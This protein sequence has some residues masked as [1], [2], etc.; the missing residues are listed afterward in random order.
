MWYLY[1]VIERL[2]SDPP[3]FLSYQVIPYK[4]LG[5][6]VEEKPWHLDESNK[7]DLM[8]K[9]LEHQKH[10]ER[11]MKKQL[12]IPIQFATVV[13][14]VEAV[15][16][17]LFQNYRLFRDALEDMAGKWEA[18]V[19]VS[20]EVKSQLKKI[21]ACDLEVQAL[22]EHA[23][24]SKAQED[25]VQVG[26]LLEAKLGERREELSSGIIAVLDTLD[27]TI[28]EHEPLENRIVL[29]RSYLLNRMNEEILLRHLTDLDHRF[30]GE[31]LFRCL[32][33][34]PPHSFCTIDIKN[35]PLIQLKEALELFE[36]TGSTTPAD[37]KEK[38]GELTKIHHPDS[39]TGSTTMFVRVCEH[40]SLLCALAGS[41]EMPFQ[42]LDVENCFVTGIRKGFPL[43]PRIKGV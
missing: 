15:K 9:L 12:V 5:V 1:G 16:S 3:F 41:R 35:V 19:V 23:I 26:V 32:T 43:P 39:K 13:E 24:Q 14:H 6:V 17:I 18:N 10:L 38:N 20:W 42:N 31:L 34:L 8:Y 7:K 11:M 40:F 27:A 36:V 30:D 29:N 4:D 28:I 37:L 22:K 33:P 2:E 25:A 21:A